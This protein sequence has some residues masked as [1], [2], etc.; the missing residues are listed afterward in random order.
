MPE[1]IFKALYGA[2]NRSPV[3]YF[4]KIHGFGFLLDCGWDDSYDLTL[5]DPIKEVLPSVNAGKFQKFPIKISIIACRSSLPHHHS[6]FLH[7]Y[8]YSS[9]LSSRYLPH[10]SPPLSC[11]P[12]RT[13]SSHLCHSPSSQ[14]GP[15][16]CL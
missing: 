1:V 10:R 9:T 6:L 13:Q 12:S 8:I 11:W 5:L 7:P 14:D 4:L 2:H 3:C 15:N 16:V